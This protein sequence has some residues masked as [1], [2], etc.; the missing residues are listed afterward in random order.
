MG[1]VSTQRVVAI[2]G[3]RIPIMAFRN[4]VALD[5]ATYCGGRYGQAVA[6]NA[7][8]ESTTLAAV[9]VPDYCI[10]LRGR[11]TCQ[12]AILYPALDG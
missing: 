10:P 4:S 8:R 5:H 12:F 9:A 7:G 3:Q 6:F 1:C 11:R 2:M